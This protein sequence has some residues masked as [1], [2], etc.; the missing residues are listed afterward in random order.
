MQIQLWITTPDWSNCMIYGDHNSFVDLHNLLYRYPQLE[1]WI[2]T[3]H[4]WRSTN[5]DNYGYPQLELWISTNTIVDIHNSLM[6][7][8]NS[9]MEIH[10]S[11]VDFHNSIYGYPHLELWT[12]TN[13]FLG[14]HKSGQLWIS[15]I[16]YMD[17][18]KCNCGYTQFIY[19]DPQFIYGDPRFIC[20]HP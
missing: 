13:A 7:V 4:L 5:L 19:W 9:F 12:S 11:F 17:I 3:I 15:R 18:Q 10:N 6:E 16:G 14:I 2:S 20:G 1:L 8:H